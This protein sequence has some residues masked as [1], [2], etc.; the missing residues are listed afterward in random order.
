MTYS[1]DIFGKTIS[2]ETLADAS[3]A[4]CADRDKSGRGASG[5]PL[6]AIKQDGEIVGYFSYNGRVWDQPSKDWQPGMM[7]V[8]DNASA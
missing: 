1:F 6:P 3:R 8:F 4:F 2:A 5:M 7:P